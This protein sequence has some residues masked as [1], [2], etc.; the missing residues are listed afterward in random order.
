MLEASEV[1]ICRPVHD[2]AGE[3]LEQAGLGLDLPELWERLRRGGA[4]LAELERDY[5]GRLT[6]LHLT[7]QALWAHRAL[8]LCWPAEDP[9]LEVSASVGGQVLDLG[10]GTSDH[11]WKLSRFAFARARNDVLALETPRVPITATLLTARASA[12]IGALARPATSREVAEQLAWIGTPDRASDLLRL[13]VKACIV[14]ACDAEGRSAE[15]R[16]TTLEQ[17]EFHDLLF[18]MRSRQGRH[19]YPM[20]ADFRF[21][22]RLPP[23]PALKPR[24]RS[25][26]TIG[27]PAPNLSLVAAG[28]P[29]FTAVLESRRSVR[30]QDFGRPIKILQLA[31]FLY[32]S[33]RVRTRYSTELGEFTSRPYPSGGASYE[34][35]IYLAANLCDGLQRGFYHYDP[36]A[37]ALHLIRPPDE[38]FEGLL[39]DAWMSAARLCRP[40][41][42]LTIASRFQR[43]SW[44]YSGMAYAAQL[45]NV[46]VLYQTFY[47]VATAMNLAGCAL[48]LGDSARFCR[49]AGTDWFAEGSVGEF[50]LGSAA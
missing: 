41:V 12:L 26:S 32:R 45:K 22:G 5:D 6:A 40:Q 48:G 11:L 47:L 17:W 13:L 4:R 38:T 27:L 49:L 1:G 7:I 18:H 25:V 29:P 21:K 46:G 23:Q 50:M 44:K 2:A 19:S 16:D 24:S 35:E 36:E 33:A 34:L 28:D 20:G 9:D 15:D 10:M 42:L 30:E 39:D 37:H 3:G 31:E 14:I 43:V 8:A